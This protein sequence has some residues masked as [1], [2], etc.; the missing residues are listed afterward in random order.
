MNEF[1]QR[2]Q[3]ISI[4]E[5]EENGSR[6]STFKEDDTRPAYIRPQPQPQPQPPAPATAPFSH[7]RSKGKDGIPEI[8][9][10]RPTFDSEQQ[11]KDEE[12]AGCCKCVIM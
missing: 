11:G 5:E 8:T 2:P 6:M 4:T 7:Y 12:G 1:G 9:I 10:T 3:E